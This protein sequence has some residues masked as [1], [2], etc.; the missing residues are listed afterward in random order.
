MADIWVHQSVPV[1]VRSSRPARSVAPARLTDRPNPNLSFLSL[2]RRIWRRGRRRGRRPAPAASDP[3]C[4]RHWPR[5]MRR[6]TPPWWSSSICA[7]CSLLAPSPSSP[8]PKL[9][10]RCRFPPSPT[11]LW[12]LGLLPELPRRTAR[13]WG[14]VVLL[15]RPRC[16][17]AELR[18]LLLAGKFFPSTL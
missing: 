4:H 17:C 2:P 16:R 14:A 1:S 13:S 7:S 9:R 18:R 11:I 12:R 5:R 3:L 10:V 6:S 15:L 8:E